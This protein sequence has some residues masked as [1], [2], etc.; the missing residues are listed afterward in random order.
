MTNSEAT[1]L[2]R[3][4]ELSAIRLKL[5]GQNRNQQWIRRVLAQGLFATPDCEGRTA[6][7]AIELGT[8]GG[9]EAS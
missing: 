3:Q 6:G 1:F 2:G 8:A 9:Q 5:R 7:Q 4:Q